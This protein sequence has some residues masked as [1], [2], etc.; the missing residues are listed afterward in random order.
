MAKIEPFLM[1]NMRNGEVLGFCQEVEDKVVHVPAIAE[2]VANA[3]FRQSIEAYAGVLNTE[4]EVNYSDVKE[5]DAHMD[6]A[7]NGLTGQLKIMKDYPEASI[8]EAAN[9]ILD[10]IDQYGSPVNLPPSEEHPVVKQMIDALHG[11]EPELLTR[12]LTKAWVDALEVR[13]ESFMKV[14]R[15]Y[16]TERASLSKGRV[17]TAREDLYRAWDTLCEAI[18]GLNAISPSEELDVLIDEINVRILSKKMA[19]KQRRNKPS[20]KSDEAKAATAE[21]TAKSAKTKSPTEIPSEQRL[22]ATISPEMPI[23]DED[24]LLH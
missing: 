17:K 19:L 13:Y 9:V 5:K 21:S 20:A 22:T 12:T 16:D 8:R 14:L 7:I 11:L 4:R 6:H 10:A 2:L 18:V 3:K 1:K 15:Q 23:L 24:A